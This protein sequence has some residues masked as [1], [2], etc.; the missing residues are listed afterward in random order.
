[1]A[2]SLSCA[3]V[4]LKAT[5]VLQLFFGTHQNCT[6]ADLTNIVQQHEDASRV[7]CTNLR[8][9]ANAPG[10][11]PD[12]VP[13][14]DYGPCPQHYDS[15]SSTARSSSPSSTVRDNPPSSD[16]SPASSIHSDIEEAPQHRQNPT[17]TIQTVRTMFAVDTGDYVIYS[18]TGVPSNHNL[19]RL[20]NSATYGGDYYRTN[21]TSSLRG[22]ATSISPHNLQL[23]TANELS[24]IH[25]SEPT[26]PY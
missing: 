2:Y 21:A 22:R 15:E 13:D 14:K 16:S 4:Q 7:S 10:I 11:S 8:L 17:A 5:T 12:N 24:L 1:M 6:T 3:T 26:R 19:A 9:P 23:S 20:R 25:I 18:T